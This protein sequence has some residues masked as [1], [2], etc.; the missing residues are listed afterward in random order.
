MIGVTAQDVPI[1]DAKATQATIT[2]NATNS[3]GTDGI[4]V[5]AADT[6]IQG[7]KIGPNDSGDNKTIEVVAD[8][9]MLRYAATAIPNGG[10][11]IYIDDFSANGDVVQSYHILQNAF[12]DGT[13][14]DIASGAGSSGPVVGREIMDNTFDL[15]NNGFNAISFNGSGG[16][17]WFVN[18]VGGALINGNTFSNSTQYIRARG[19]YAESQFDWASYWNDNTFDK[20]TIALVATDPF[21]VRPYS[22]SVFTNVRRIGGTIQGTLDSALAG[23]TVLAKAGTY[24]EAVSIT[25]PVTLQGAG[26]GVTVV[27]GDDTG[28]GIGIASSVS[29]VSVSDLS[30]QDFDNGAALVPGGGTQQN[31]TFT[32]MESVSNDVHGMFLPGA[33]LDNVSLT[34]VNSS[35]NGLPGSGG[36]GVYFTDGTRTNISITGGTFDRNALV[37][38]DL[39]DGS[40]SGITIAG[41]EV[42]GNGDSGIGVLGATG[43]AANLI[44]SNVVT[45]NGRFG[46]EIKTPTGN[47]QASG[48][49]SVVVSNNAVTRTIAATDARDYAGIAVFRRAVGPLNADQPSGVVV[50][51]NM[52]SGYHRKPIGS[53]GDGFG[54]VVEGLGHVVTGNIVSDNDVDIQIQSNNT[55]TNDQNT[56][57]FDR[58]SA[59]TSSAV[60]HGNKILTSTNFDLRNLGAPITDATCN[61]YDNATG[62]AASKVV[63]LLVTVPFYVSPN[64]AV[65]C[66]IPTAATAT[67][68]DSS[69]DV[70]WTA[71][72]AES[73]PAITGYLVT[74]SPGGVTCSTSAALTCTVAGLT[75]GTAYT[76]TVQ[77]TNAQ[78]SGA[79]SAPSAPVTPFAVASEAPP[80]TPDFNPI[81]PQRV[82]DTRAGQSP[83]HCARSPRR[84]SAAPTC[85]RSR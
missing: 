31:L 1:D 67:A 81:D 30:V 46:I 5:E 71:P 73:G 23:D 84:K 16:V 69:A 32:N 7:V 2:T 26:A 66:G 22:Y 42:V 64:T 4:F 72:A 20:A 78:G 80:G 65:P 70:S 29:D 40:A 41:N 37:G 85:W 24:D 14:V 27:Q 49:G 83:T 36:R 34:S 21:D 59:S 57:F 60:I 52:V 6:T 82:F 76:F 28:T 39:N 62:P 79:S 19:V 55:D 77:A 10:G 15:G 56:P 51:D 61:A 18:P 48:P 74:A 45:D 11:A 58:G 33:S 63:G 8:N 53:T 17:P 9:F 43:P 25:R 68:G 12:L 38:I 75:N 50:S 44:D 54:I 13:S 3:F 47:G 35:D